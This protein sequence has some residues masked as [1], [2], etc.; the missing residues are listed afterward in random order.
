MCGGVAGLPP[1]SGVMAIPPSPFYSPA[2]QYLTDNLARFCFCKTDEMLD[3][4]VR[5]YRGHL[6]ELGWNQGKDHI[7]NLTVSA[8]QYYATIVPIVW[9]SIFLKA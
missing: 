8:G 5:R 7:C 6:E 3:E 2:H 1:M 4:A 9:L